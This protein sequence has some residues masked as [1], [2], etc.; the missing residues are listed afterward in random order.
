ML[1][2]KI[3]ASGF[4]PEAG[5]KKGLTVILDAHTDLIK[6]RIVALFEMLCTVMKTDKIT[7]HILGLFCARGLSGIH[8]RRW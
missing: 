4:H 8:C 1:P 3:N 7:D 5:V 6:V 2:K